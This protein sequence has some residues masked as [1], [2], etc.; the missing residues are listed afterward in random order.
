MNNSNNPNVNSTS[1]NTTDYEEI[2]DTLQDL[3]SINENLNKE[4][5][6]ELKQYISIIKA[7]IEGKQIEERSVDTTLWQVTNQPQF[8]FQKYEYRVKGEAQELY[9][10]VYRTKLGSVHISTP[11]CH[12]T[13]TS[14]V[15]NKLK[16]NKFDILEERK[17]TISG[18]NQ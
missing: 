9:Y 2:A 12:E 13:Y 6:K 4:E 16:G 7:F 15:I 8:N 14:T 10:C 5:I 18:E 11:S 3:V 17:I 1:K